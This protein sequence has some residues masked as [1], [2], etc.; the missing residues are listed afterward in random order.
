MKTK[1]HSTKQPVGHYWINQRG[2][3]NIP[4]TNE[5]GKHI[6]P[7]LRDNK[8][9]LCVKLIVIQTYQRN[10]K[11]VKWDNTGSGDHPYA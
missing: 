2:N 9:I 7:K 3:Q 8:T 10:K 11:Y 1:Q 5:N 4:K 6:D